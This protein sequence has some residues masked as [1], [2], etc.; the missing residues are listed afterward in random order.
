MTEQIPRPL[1][2]RI[3]DRLTGSR[4]RAAIG[5]GGALLAVLV[6]FVLLFGS[7]TGRELRLNPDGRTVEQSEIICPP[8]R[9]A[10]TRSY[11]KADPS[12]PDEIRICVDTGRGRL[13]T[14]GLYVLL[15][16]VVTLALTRLPGRSSRHSAGSDWDHAIA[17]A[18]EGI[19]T[20][21]TGA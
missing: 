2:W 21:P 4:A 8:A 12:V 9:T 14:A 18:R 1:R 7:Y 3:A 13:F 11:V 16:A 20:P 19:R 10:L 6:V 17:K 15:I 5:L